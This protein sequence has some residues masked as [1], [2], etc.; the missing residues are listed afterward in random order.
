MSKRDKA[1]EW[2]PPEFDEVE[3]M[4]KEM[5]A[6]K[7]TILVVLWT[8]PAAL[9]SWGLTLAGVAV[10]AGF[11]GLGMMFLLKWI[12]PLLNVDI[13]GYKRKDW[14]GHGVTFFFS[15]LAFWILLLNPPFADLTN[16]VILG[17]AVDGISV[18]CGQTFVEGNNTS[19]LTVRAGDNVGVTLV[20]AGTLDLSPQSG[21]WARGVPRDAGYDI[22]AYD[23]AGHSSS[24][25]RVTITS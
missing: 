16:P 17:V 4:K 13:S 21:V 10:V 9:I 20:R 12:F 8:I 14:L 25:C 11:A 5:R 2:K 7:A 23:G 15:W 22:V 18:A 1:A 19:A 3:F 6:A 24:P